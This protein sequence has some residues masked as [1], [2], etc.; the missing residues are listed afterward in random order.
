MAPSSWASCR[1]G[2]WSSRA[3]IGT[4]CEK[5]VL[6]LTWFV[7]ADFDAPVLYVEP[8]SITDQTGPV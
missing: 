6:N 4:W 3:S 8:P 5:W 1:S 7:T 2:S